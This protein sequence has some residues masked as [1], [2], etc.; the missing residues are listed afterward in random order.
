[1]RDPYREGQ[2]Y[3]FRVAMTTLCPHCLASTFNGDTNPATA[4]QWKG[5]HIRSAVHV[6]KGK[7]RVC[8]AAKLIPFLLMFDKSLTGEPDQ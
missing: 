3:A 6:V 5:G 4:G 1:M 7:P 2:L 8:R